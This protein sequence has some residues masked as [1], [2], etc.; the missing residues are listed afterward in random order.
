SVYLKGTTIGTACDQTGHYYLV[1][2]PEGSFTII[3]SAI[4]YKP[5]EFSIQTQTGK[6]VEI[7]FELLPDLLNLQEVVVSSDRNA[8]KR[9]DAP[10]IV[11][12]ITPSIFK[13][14]Q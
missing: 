5:Q 4:G 14:T 10:V 2:V 11:N 7:K 1:N 8:R 9:N 12:T 13:S 6:T 3:A